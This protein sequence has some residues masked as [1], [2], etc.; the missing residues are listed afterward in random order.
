MIKTFTFGK[1]YFNKSNN[2]PFLANTSSTNYSKILDDIILADIIKKNSY[3][4]TKPKTD[5]DYL[6]DIILNAK[7]K[8]SKLATATTFLANYSKNKKKFN[9]PYKLNTTYTLSDGTPII[10]YDDEIQIGFDYYKYTD[11]NDILF[12]K[13]LT[14][15]KKKTIIDIYI[16]GAKNI[17]INIL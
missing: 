12:L 6:S 11:F 3:L 10:F 16:K 15:A 17:N 9:L 13:N 7:T 14:A 8:N 2:N 5:D 4:F 1:T